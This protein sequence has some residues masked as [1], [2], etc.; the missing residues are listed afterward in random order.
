VK[1]RGSQKWQQAT[2]ARRRKR[3]GE[4]VSNGDLYRAISA[5][6]SYF[7]AQR[8]RTGALAEEAKR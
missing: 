8:T 2:T 5:G 6:Y 3:S 4:W 7:L 1:K